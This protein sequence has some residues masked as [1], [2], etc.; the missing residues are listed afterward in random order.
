MEG[1]PLKASLLVCYTPWGFQH[2]QQFWLSLAIPL[3]VFCLED[4]R[5]WTLSF[6]LIFTFSQL[7]MMTLYSSSLWLCVLGVLEITSVEI[8]VVAVKAINSNYY[9]AM[10]KKGKLYGSVS[11]LI[12]FSKHIVLLVP[13]IWMVS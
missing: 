4:N 1:Q 11:S 2:V 9:L 6:V 12:L 3:F 8:G 7:N 13:K 10:N 5:K